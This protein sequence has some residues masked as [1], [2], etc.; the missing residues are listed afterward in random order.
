MDEQEAKKV[1]KRTLV[2]VAV[3]AA[4]TFADFLPVASAIQVVL[5]CIAILV[6]LIYMVY[7]LATSCAKPVRKK[8]NNSCFIL[9]FMLF[10]FMLNTIS[11]LPLSEDIVAILRLCAALIA[12][13]G[14]IVFIAFSVRRKALSENN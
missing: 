5:N 8:G 9:P 1:R 3:I 4:L 7:F 13:I 6:C 10:V 14:S 2:V 11:F 12:I